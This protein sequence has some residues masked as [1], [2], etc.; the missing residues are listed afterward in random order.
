M[1]ADTQRRSILNEFG[2]VQAKMRAWVPPANPHEARFLELKAVID[3]WGESVD[4][5]QPYA[6]ETKGFTLAMKPRQ[7]QRDMGPAVQRAA[8]EAFQKLEVAVDHKVVKFDPFTVFS[9]TIELITKH[10]GKPF[11]DQIA[12]KE[13]TGRR[14]FTVTSKAV[15]A[16]RKA[17]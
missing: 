1:P 16:L 11:L 3:S 6:L 12:P 8:F 13:P 2:E 9:T 14:T 10:L 15:P 7:L 4:A 5:K 17:G